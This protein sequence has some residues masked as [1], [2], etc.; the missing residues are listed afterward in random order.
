MGVKVAFADSTSSMKIPPKDRVPYFFT[1][2]TKNEVCSI[3]TDAKTLTTMR[4]VWW[5]KMPSLIPATAN[6]TDGTSFLA[7]FFSVIFTASGS[8]SKP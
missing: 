2:L 5:P 7:A 4:S 1:I 8:I 3:K 6:A